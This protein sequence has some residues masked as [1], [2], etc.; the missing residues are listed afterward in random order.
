MTVAAPVESGRQP[1]GNLEAVTGGV[2]Q[3]DVAGWA[4]DP[5]T[6][7]SIPVHVYVDGA[8]VPYVADKQ[9]PDVAAA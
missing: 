7:A 4:L 5:D 8:G 1:I 2:G 3:I 6:T 9:R